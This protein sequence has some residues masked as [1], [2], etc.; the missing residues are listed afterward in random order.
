MEPR[1][2]TPTDPR[3]PARPAGALAELAGDPST[4][5]RFL[6]MAGGA[7]VATSLS[8]L[9][10]ACGKDD[11]PGNGLGGA[12]VAAER[13]GQGD[14]GIVGYALYL[15]LLEVAF[16][17]QAVKSGKLTGRALELAKRFGEEERAHADTL[18]GT[19]KSLGGKPPPGAKFAFPTSDP[20]ELLLTA[21]QVESLGAGAYLGQVGRIQ[22]KQVLAAALSIHTVEA[23]HAAAL[24]QLL[25]RPITPDGS[26]GAPATS[27]DVLQQTRSFVTV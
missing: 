25:G 21:A 18:S 14:A 27:I 9:I 15:E 13:F 26:F 11:T 16:Y 8:A 23:R 7:A 20:Q 5:S 10:A 2:Q 19:L 1:E 22:S 3:E 4:R 12:G 24:A 6:R 17:D